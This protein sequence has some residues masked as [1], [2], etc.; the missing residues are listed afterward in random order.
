MHNVRSTASRHWLT[1]E[2]VAAWELGEFAGDDLWEIGFAA[3]RGHFG[4][5]VEVK[6]WAVRD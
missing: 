2:R 3:A 1:R 5:S 4:I 6:E